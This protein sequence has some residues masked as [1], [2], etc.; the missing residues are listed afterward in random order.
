MNHLVQYSAA[1]V[2]AAVLAGCSSSAEVGGST[3][4]ARQETLRGINSFYGNGENVNL[5]KAVPRL[6]AA[7]ETGDPVA[8]FFAGESFRRGLNGTAVNSLKA[9]EAFR[10]AVPGLCS[11]LKTTGDPVAA[12]LLGEF[13]ANGCAGERDEAAAAAL[14]EFASEKNFAPAKVRL[15]SA[16]LSGSGV[17]A[18]PARAE[19]LLLQAA[20][21]GA[22]EANFEL[23]KLYMSQNKQDEAASQ[24]KKAVR[25]NVAEALYV[26]AIAAA[27]SPKRAEKAPEIYRQAMQNGSPG[28]TFVCATKYT[29]NPMERFEL[30]K[31]AVAGNQISAILP[32]AQAYLDQ[33]MPDRPMALAAALLAVRLDPKNSEAAELVAAINRQTGL[34]PVVSTVWNG[35]LNNGGDLLQA[36]FGL[37]PVLMAYRAGSPAGSQRELAYLLDEGCAEGFYLSNSWYQFYEYQLP[38][39]WLKDIFAKINA[40]R[41]ALGAALQYT[42]AAGLAGD[43]RMQSAGAKAFSALL[44]ANAAQ[45][46]AQ[47]SELRKELADAVPALAALPAPAADQTAVL[48]YR[49]MKEILQDIA[50]LCAA[51]GML[52]AGNQAGAYRYLA[53]NKIKHAGDEALICFVNHFCNPLLVDKAEFSRTTGIAAGK[54]GSYARPI[55][56]KFFSFR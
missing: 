36:E 56:Q 4:E 47:S 32:L 22:A 11:E 23:Y 7:A 12:F 34:L 15:A 44:A 20:E 3:T 49:A 21:A 52:L 29:D 50:N 16:L 10:K 45:P 25:N 46:K 42:V 18:D 41:D 55:A 8:L 33:P 40:K 37:T 13:L 19:A 30:L 28:A 39:V 17:T 43:G 35:R 54:L 5:A 38:L 24:L 27:S 31:A 51:N 14:Y 48:E 1:A 26:D 2:L 6:H 9:A 53:Q